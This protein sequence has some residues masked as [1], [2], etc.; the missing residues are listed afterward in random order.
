MLSK[1][2]LKVMISQVNYL[3][4]KASELIMK[5]YD[6]VSDNANANDNAVSFKDDNSPL[7]AADIACNDYLVKYTNYFQL[8]NY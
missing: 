2:K 5:I 1:Q 6:N 3:V 8:S 4:N 7:T